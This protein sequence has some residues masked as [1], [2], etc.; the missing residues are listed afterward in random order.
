M[1]NDMR[2]TEFDIRAE[3]WRVGILLLSG[4]S[5]ALIAGAALATVYFHLSGKS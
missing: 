2:K 3:V 4:F 5:T 1:H